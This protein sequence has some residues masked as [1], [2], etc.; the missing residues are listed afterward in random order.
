MGHSILGK[1][2]DMGMRM[3]ELEQSIASLLHHSGLDHAGQNVTFDA[4]SSLHTTMP[5]TK[6]NT[7]SK[8]QS[9]LHL[10]STT[11]PSLNKAKVVESASTESESSVVTPPIHQSVVSSRTRVTIE[12]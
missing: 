1:M 11:Q 3:D 4:L 10:T 12:I 8:S 2:D 6:A 5:A 9:A 7:G